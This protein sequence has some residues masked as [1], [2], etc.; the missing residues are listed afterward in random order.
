M[1]SVTLPLIQLPDGRRVVFA[2][3][4]HGRRVFIEV[5]PTDNPA[6]LSR[7]AGEDFKHVILAMRSSM[8]SRADTRGAKIIE[9]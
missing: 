9:A 3:N 1:S 8:K 4:Y 5:L 2:L 6:M 7:Q